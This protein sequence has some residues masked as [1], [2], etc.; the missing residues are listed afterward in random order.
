MNTFVG[1]KFTFYSSFISENIAN[2]NINFLSV[3]RGYEVYL[4]LSVPPCCYP[5]ASP[6]QFKAYDV[7]EYL[8]YVVRT[9]TVDSIPQ[10]MIRNVIL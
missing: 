5:V 8:V 10:A 7:L 3:L 9:L 4:F 1:S 6:Q 2:L